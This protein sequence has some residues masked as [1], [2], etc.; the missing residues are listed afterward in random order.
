MNGGPPPLVLLLAGLPGVGKT[1]LAERL[2]P[3]LD[4]VILNRDEIRDHIFPAVALDYSAAQNK[5]AT[6]AMLSVLDYLL[7]HAR[8]PAIVLDGKPFSKRSE[9]DAV[10]AI[11]RRHHASLLVLHCIAPPEIV[12]ARLRRDLIDPRNQRAQ[13]DPAKAT[14]IRTEFEP[15]AVPHIVIDTSTGSPD[16]LAHRA[17]A[18]INRRR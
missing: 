3:G 12:E 17:L 14:R 15:I 1:R 5:V 4:G 8:L 10:A 11:V 9:I 2:A 13:R 18:E 7:G 16:E 6:D